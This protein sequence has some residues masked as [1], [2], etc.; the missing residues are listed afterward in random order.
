M[1]QNRAS[2]R[3]RQS[4]SLSRRR[5]LAGAATLA[6]T[7]AVPPVVRSADGAGKYRVAVIGHTGRGDYG[8]D[9]DKAWLDL[10]EVEIVAV[11]DANE[12]GRAEAAK[13]LKAPKQYADYRQMLDEAKPDLLGVCPRWVDQHRDMVVAAAEHGVKGIYMEKPLCRTLA[14]ADQMIAACRK[15]KVKAALAFQT[16]YSPKLLVIRELIAAGKLGQL[17]EFR[18][19]GKEDARG[20]AE[21]LWVLGPHLMDLILHFGGGPS[22][23]TGSVLEQGRPIGK[24]DVRPGSEGIGLLAGDEVH[25]MYR[26]AGGAMAYFDSVRNAGGGPRFAL[27]ICGSKGVIELGTN[28]MPPAFL[29]PHTSWSM[30]RGKKKWIEITSAGV[31]KPEPLKGAGPHEGNVAALK[32]LIAAVEKDGTPLADIA[33]A[34]TGL[35]MIVAPFE[36]QRQGKPVPIPLANRQDPLASLS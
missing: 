16:R 18:A 24:Q 1:I 36:S 20:G 29:L 9:L 10:R 25:A 8:H 33:A 35:E 5:F 12:A 26:M 13:R 6:G 32:D 21:D 27:W 31:D 3:H 7:L 2:Q 4:P 14:E 19:R 30:P 15:H 22:W 11:A 23:C 34:R 28:Y 17:L